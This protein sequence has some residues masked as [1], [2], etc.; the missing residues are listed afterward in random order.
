MEQHSSRRSDREAFEDFGV[1]KGEG[2]HLFE[3][4]DVGLEAAYWVEGDGGWDAEGVGIGEGC[5]STSSITISTRFDFEV[6]ERRKKDEM[7]N[8]PAQPS[9]NSPVLHSH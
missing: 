7:T 6:R 5:S 9:P 2:N 1:E 8:P 4:L 3:L